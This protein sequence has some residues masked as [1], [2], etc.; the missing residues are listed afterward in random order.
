MSE[1]R[2]KND[3]G[4]LAEALFGELDRLDAC[5]TAEEIETEVMR[6]KAVEAISGK[7]IDNAQVV[8]QAVRLKAAVEDSTVGTIAPLPP[9]LLGEGEQK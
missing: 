1:T 3:L 8:I 5:E 9:M 7:V 4:D 6:A 2:K